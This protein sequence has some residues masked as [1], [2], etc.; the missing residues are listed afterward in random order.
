MKTNKQS[1]VMYS[2]KGD[3]DARL[4][5]VNSQRKNPGIRPMDHAALH[6]MGPA[7]LWEGKGKHLE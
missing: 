3:S 4:R 2:P 6:L 7:L 5:S 1:E